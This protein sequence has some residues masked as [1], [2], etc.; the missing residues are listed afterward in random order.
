[1]S[2]LKILHIT[3]FRDK[4]GGT[5]AARLLSNHDP[6]NSIL[7]FLE[8]HNKRLTSESI[9]PAEYAC[10]ARDFPFVR[11]VTKRLVER[12][13]GII[14]H[15]HGR[16]PGLW[17][18]ILRTIYPNSARVVLSFHG[19]ASF[20]VIKRMSVALQQS[21]LSLV[22]DQFIAATES[23]I[24]LFRHFPS[25]APIS[26]IPNAFNADHVV[27]WTPRPIR[28]IGFCARFERPKLHE[29]LIRVVACC[30]AQISEPLKL[31]FSGDGIL[32]KRVDGL[33]HE[34][35]GMNYTSLGHI[36][37]MRDFYAQIDAFAHFSL[38]EGM[39]LSLLDALACGMPCIAT[40]VI[41][42]KDLIEQDISGCLVPVGDISTAA[43][44]LIRLVE[45]SQFAEK[46]AH[47]AGSR[48]LTQF[49]GATLW[50]SHRK[51]YERLA[52]ELP[53]IIS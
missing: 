50:E 13:G 44:A 34:L 29:D 42:C 49:S 16:R 39:P 10:H 12:D 6:K 26:V 4:G 33:G 19:M 7:L 23:E 53:G 11:N 43:T 20:S 36:P 5:A 15:C 21:A 37:N 9:N 41:G 28:R 2:P 18:Q 31:V 51:I 52:A 38:Y 8:R 3:N 24:S 40:D 47:T 35:L 46:I 22:T 14:I 45:N 32:R 27:K 48:A 17:G 30:N 25:A 1:M